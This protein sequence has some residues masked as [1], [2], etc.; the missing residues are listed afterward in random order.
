LAKEVLAL[1]AVEQIAG[2]FKVSA[3]VRVIGVG[4]WEGERE[5]ERERKRERERERERESAREREKGG[6]RERYPELRGAGVKRG[7][8][9][10]AD[11][12]PCH[13]PCV[14]CIIALRCARSTANRR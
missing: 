4:V 9:R 1:A 6:E 13:C 10:N 2:T 11:T 8:G 5:R 3:G 14:P 12:H 7:A